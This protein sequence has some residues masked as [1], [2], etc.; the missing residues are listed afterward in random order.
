MSSQTLQF[1]HASLQYSQLLQCASSLNSIL[2]ALPCKT[3]D[4]II[5]Q[6]IDGLGSEEIGKLLNQ[7][8][9]DGQDA[10]IVNNLLQSNLESVSR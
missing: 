6:V 3:S 1:I 8:L 7:A 5:R 4:R 9:L 10:D 2:L